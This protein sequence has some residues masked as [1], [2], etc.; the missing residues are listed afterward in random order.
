MTG[1]AVSDPWE[2]DRSVAPPV[3]GSPRRACGLLIVDDEPAIRGVL[4]AALRGQGFTV[5]LASRADEAVALYREHRLLIDMI[6][7]DV[8]M[9]GRD[10]PGTLIALREVDP[11]VR[12]S[13]MS[14]DTGIYTEENLLDMGAVAVFRKPFR[15]TEF[16]QQ[17]RHLATS[18]DLRDHCDEDRSS[19]H[20]GCRDHSQCIQQP[21]DGVD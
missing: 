21:A 6:L 16:V 14:G 17:L 18:I 9:P 11:H 2:T 8:R 4:E 7:L 12:F 20:G 13:F 15:L 5:W 1:T 10:G 19:N 3:N